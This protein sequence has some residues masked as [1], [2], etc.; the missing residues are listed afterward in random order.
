LRSVLTLIGIAV[1]IAAVLYVVIL[2]EVTKA[3]INERLES[4]GSN[5]LVIRPGASRFRG[6]RT[7]QNVE[8]LTWDQA[9]EIQSKSHVIDVTVPLFSRAASTEYQ[10][11][12]WSATVTGTIPEY[13][14]VNNIVPAAGRF[15]TPVEV[16]GRSRVCVLGATV[17]QEL[18]ADKSPVGKSVL[19]NS[20]RFDVVGLLEAKGESWHSPDGQIYIPLTTAQ[21]RL[22]GGR[23]IYPSLPRRNASSVSTM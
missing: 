2:G 17:H 11:K 6:V 23:S 18:F 1:G 9:R 8:S 20:K 22:F 5:V 4:L 10:D 16:V 15:F 21:E 12:N 13:S 7:A 19:I 14:P 3:R